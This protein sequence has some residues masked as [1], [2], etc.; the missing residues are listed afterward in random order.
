ME[1]AQLKFI[2]MG[3]VQFLDQV[4]VLPVA[5]QDIGLVQ[6]VQKT[7][8]IPHVFLDMVV[9]PVVVQRQVRG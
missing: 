9:V 1:A 8:V 7:V 2:D 6:T 4:V 3:V 5:V